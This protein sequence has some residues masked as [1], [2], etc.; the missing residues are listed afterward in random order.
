VTSTEN[1]LPTQVTGS[2]VEKALEIKDRT[3]SGGGGLIWGYISNNDDLDGPRSV[4]PVDVS[5]YRDKSIYIKNDYDVT[6]NS[7]RVYGLSEARNRGE[8]SIS[9]DDYTLFYFDIDHEVDPGES[10]YITSDEYP[11]LKKTSI[12]LLV[13]V[14]NKDGTEVN[15]GMDVIIFGIN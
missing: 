9:R 11:G 3:W 15:G 10:L 7:I 8:D 2:I 14:R 13:R 4:R 6:L 5:G 1:P 12:G